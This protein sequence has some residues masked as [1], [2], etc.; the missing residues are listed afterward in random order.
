MRLAVAAAVVLLLAACSGE[1]APEPTPSATP[2]PAASPA[3]APAIDD[4]A[5]PRPRPG[6]VAAAVLPAPELEGPVAAGAWTLKAS[7]TGASAL[8]GVAGSEARFAVRCDPATRTIAFA[9]SV[10]AGGTIKLVTANG[11][12][13]FAAQAEHAGL[14]GI[15]AAAPAQYTFLTQSLA[16]AEGGFAVQVDGGEPL[17]LPWDAAVGQ[18][19]RS[20]Q[21]G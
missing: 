18:V 9:R 19:I 10:P 14:P 20:C 5:Q 12:A 6:G 11:S 16:R 21:P 15:V 17:R 4:R 1:P 2:S 7:A 13:T 8:F 3:P